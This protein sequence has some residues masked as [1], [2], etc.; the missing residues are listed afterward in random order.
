M[1]DFKILNKNY[2]KLSLYRNY[3][4]NTKPKNMPQG[5]KS[6]LITN[7]NGLEISSQ[8]GN[9]LH[10]SKKNMLDENYSFKR[11]TTNY[12]KNATSYPVNTAS[13][14]KNVNKRDGPIINIKSNLYKKKF[15]K[16]LT[17]SKKNDYSKSQNSKDRTNSNINIM[18]NITGLILNRSNLKLNIIPKKSNLKYMNFREN[19]LSI[20]SNKNIGKSTSISKSKSKS[21]NKRE[22]K[23]YNNNITQMFFNKY[24][25]I[26]LDK[27]G[28][29]KK[30]HKKSFNYLNNKESP[31]YINNKFSND[32]NISDI[33]KLNSFNLIK[34]IQFRGVRKKNKSSNLLI[35]N[36]NNI[37]NINPK[38]KNFHN[39]R[40][41]SNNIIISK[42]ETNK[43]LNSKN[44]NNNKIL[45]KN[46][47]VINN[48]NINN[49]IK[50]NQNTEKNVKKYLTENHI[51]YIVNKKNSGKNKHQ[52]K[53]LTNNINNTNNKNKQIS[54]KEI[55]NESNHNIHINSKN[56]NNNSNNNINIHKQNKNNNN[57]IS[58]NK[59]KLEMTE[60]VIYDYKTNKKYQNMGNNFSK[61][62][63]DKHIYTKKENKLINNTNTNPNINEIENSVNTYKILNERL[64]TEYNDI[65]LEAIDKMYEQEQ[66]TDDININ[67]KNTRSKKN[68]EDNSFRF[69]YPDGDIYNRDDE[70]FIENNDENIDNIDLNEKREKELDETESPLKMDTDKVTVENSGVLSFDQVKDIICYYNMNNTDKQSE[71]LFQNKE[72]EI[73]DMNYKNKYLN[74]FFEQKENENGSGFGMQSE[75]NN[76]DIM[77]DMISINTFNLKYP[78]NSIFSIDTEYSSKMKK[79]NNKNLVKN[80]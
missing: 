36:I 78:N 12:N 29:R 32:I 2:S 74:F 25:K 69:Y 71:F 26:K 39:L 57:N 60:N 44:S 68:S 65:S 79:K 58:S 28:H 52:K 15:E 67:N 37:N 49:N 55:K 30:T 77:D 34:N 33:N 47:L 23:S 41:N 7:S 73:F 42:I 1:N 38:Q 80:I 43:N 76:N 50:T 62:S 51:M 6:I 66:D 61:N 16:F 10:F 56:D 54:L 63:K 59:P 40:T 24:L 53:P 18:N 19:N 5:L 48:N 46:S 8:L 75:N 3:K 4:S 14:M 17:N 13:N 21:K 35:S 72:R 20:N 70:F 31:R 9:F 22:N 64:K 11:I 45:N 27:M